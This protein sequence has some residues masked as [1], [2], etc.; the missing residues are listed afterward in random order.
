MAPP[1]KRNTQEGM[2]TAARILEL[3]VNPVRGNFD[4]AH[5]KEINRR[6]FQ[7]LPSLGFDK[8]T[9]GVFRPA[10]AAG[11]DW[12][13]N[14]A[15]ETVKVPSH[16]AYSC[17]DK[18]AQARLADI[19]ER[20]APATLSKLKTAEFT[21]TIGRLYVEADYIHP[22]PD[23]NSRTLREFTRELAE[24][25]GY[26]LDWSRFAGSAA[27]RDMLCIARD[28][29]VNA[30]ALPNL[31]HDGTRRDVTTTMDQLGG[32]RELPDLLRDVV[33]PTRALAFAR[34]S[35]HEAL[36][37]HPELAEA[38]KMLHVTQTYLAAKAPN[39][40][41]VQQAAMGRIVRDVQTRLDAGETTGF[42]RERGAQ[43]AKRDKRQQQHNEPGPEHDR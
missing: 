6:I 42:S 15:L 14:R 28:L 19:L 27:G 24:R 5:L 9:P 21:E 43:V 20:A 1:D 17:M 40:P 33:K 35:E 10:V 3:R 41:E 37:A 39:R 36:S 34:V 23:G 31:R 8:V 38:Y 11:N 26:E 29:A 7:D 25:S 4:V 18:P 2:Y 12:I 16:V 32:N 13:K 22:F 30:L